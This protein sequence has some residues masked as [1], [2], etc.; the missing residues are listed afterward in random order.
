[1]A[2]TSIGKSKSSKD[3]AKATR[4]E[5]DFY[6]R[7]KQYNPPAPAT[8]HEIKSWFKFI[9]AIGPAVLVQIHILYETFA[10]NR[11]E[12][13]EYAKHAHTLFNLYCFEGSKAADTK[14]FITG[15]MD[16]RI[17]AKRLTAEEQALM[18]RVQEYLIAVWSLKIK[19]E[20]EIEDDKKIRKGSAMANKEDRMARNVLAH[21][22]LESKLADVF[23]VLNEGETWPV[24]ILDPLKK[25]ASGA[26]VLANFKDVCKGL[27]SAMIEVLENYILANWPEVLM[28]KDNDFR[29]GSRT[30][31]ERIITND[32]W[33]IGMICAYALFGADPK[34]T[35]RQMKALKWKSQLWSKKERAA[36]LSQFMG[37]APEWFKK[38][39]VERKRDFEDHPFVMNVKWITQSLLLIAGAPTDKSVIPIGTAGG[40]ECLLDF[41]TLDVKCG[42]QFNASEAAHNVKEGIHAKVE[43]AYNHCINGSGPFSILGLQGSLFYSSVNSTDLIGEGVQL[44]KSNSCTRYIKYNGDYTPAL[45]NPGVT[46]SKMKNIV[47]KCNTD[48]AKSDVCIP[49]S[50]LWDTASTYTRVYGKKTD[51][52]SKDANLT[53]AAGA[54]QMRYHALKEN[55][56]MRRA[57]VYEKINERSMKEFDKQI[58][59]DAIEQKRKM[60]EKAMEDAEVTITDRDEEEDDMFS[61]D[62]NAID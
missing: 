8:E 39:V 16:I 23:E 6:T 36:Y 42:F 41:A 20:E 37:D 60:A 61:V 1:M 40:L 53:G 48:L 18:Q 24:D 35:M 38:F 19:T 10:K 28:K 26:Y 55:A 17:P 33:V 51:F 25:N 56:G 32:A 57:A 49:V 22:E 13:I 27:G 50:V 46:Y 30:F 2:S 45:K 34:K 21:A 52:T 5:G 3:E 47:F 43:S 58:A 7:Q 59:Q 31:V 62:S 12:N 14:R 54:L 44:A 11:R 29:P 15:D 4:A 9:H